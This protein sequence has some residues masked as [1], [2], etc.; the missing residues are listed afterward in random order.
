MQSEMG[1]QS[2]QPSG[3]QP[4]GGST[5][6]GPTGGEAA[7]GPGFSPGFSSCVDVIGSENELIVLMDT[8]GFEK[9]EIDIEADEH[10]LILTAERSPDTEEDH[11]FVQQE[12]PTT[13]QREIPLSAEVEI[14]EAEATY[15]KGVTRITI[16]RHEE[17]EG[18][19]TIG[20]Q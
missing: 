15:E 3:Q 10:S 12:R 18:R 7:P 14:N 5:S 6:M 2:G 16:P 20:F 8:P 11:Q 4:A 17:D 9:D 13:I 1:P 19:H